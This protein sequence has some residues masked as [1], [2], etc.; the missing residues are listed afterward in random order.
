MRTYRG[1]NTHNDEYWNL[2]T[3]N[4]GLVDNIFT[5]NLVIDI[6]KSDPRTEEE[7]FIQAK[8]LKVEE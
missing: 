4:L 7:D 5:A 6:K 3:N 1:E 2:N 8:T